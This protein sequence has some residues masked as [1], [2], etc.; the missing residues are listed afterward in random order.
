MTNC[1]LLL[2]AA[3]AATSLAPVVLF[4]GSIA[5]IGLLVRWPGGKE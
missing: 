3:L 4:V 5:A 1:D 2:R